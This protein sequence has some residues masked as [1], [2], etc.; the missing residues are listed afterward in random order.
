MLAGST[1]TT[2]LCQQWTSEEA[3][4]AIYNSGKMTNQQA[5]DFMKNMKVGG[6]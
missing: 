3:A 4:D 6:C 1:Q 5:V 2:S